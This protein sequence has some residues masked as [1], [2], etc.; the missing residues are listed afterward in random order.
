[1]FT[2]ETYSVALILMILSVL[3]WGSWPNFLKAAPNWRMEYFYLDYAIGFMIT[4][5]ILAATLGSTSTVGL[6]FLQRLSAAGN[7]ELGFAALGG[8]IWSLGNVLFLVAILIAGLA[9]AFPITIVL[10]TVLGVGLSYWSNPV[11]EIHWLAGGVV[12]LAAAAVA[13]AAAYKRL[14]SSGAAS[15]T[16][17]IALALIAGVLVG[18]FPPFVG[19]A[20]TSKT[21][22]DSYLVCLSFMVGATVAAIVAVPI[23]LTHPLVGEVGSFKGF[24]EGKGR[25]HLL[26]LAAGAVWCLGTVVNFASAGFVGVAISWAIGSGAP[27]VGALWGILFWKEFKGADPTAKRRIGLSLALYI[28]GVVVV[29]VAYQKK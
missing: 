7:R 26:G 25:W 22:L 14:N 24:L 28:V 23:L 19:A 15:K 11:G 10:A 17:A 9:V 8:F 29:A 18:L 5:L 2:P 12:L 6:D 27:M 16:R 20:L 1:M 3:C 4:I 13:N 21:P